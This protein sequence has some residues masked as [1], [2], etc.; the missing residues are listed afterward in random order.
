M[1]QLDEKMEKSQGSAAL[2]HAVR[3]SSTMVIP[4]E[5]R[6]LQGIVKY[7]LLNLVPKLA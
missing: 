4:L 3:G 5:Q 7:M 2:L 1:L 6:P